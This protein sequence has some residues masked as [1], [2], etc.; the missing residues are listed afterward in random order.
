MSLPAS[1]VFEIMNEVVKAFATLKVEP[2]EGEVF[3]FDGIK[4]YRDDDCVWVA[5]SPWTFPGQ[6]KNIICQSRNY[7]LL[8]RDLLEWILDG[9][10]S[11]IA[12]T[13]E[14]EINGPDENE[15]LL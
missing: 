12:A 15:D 11:T 14:C 1:A 9:Y 6:T 13:K 10:L 3:L 4:V 7:Y 8:L 5:E 2:T